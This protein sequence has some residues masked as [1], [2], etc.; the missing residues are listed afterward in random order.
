MIWYLYA[1]VDPL[2]PS[3]ARYVG[4]TRNVK[5]RRHVHTVRRFGVNP[6]LRAWKDKLLTAG[7]APEMRILDQF[8]SQ[9][10]A[11]EREWR[12]ILRW[13]RRGAC[14]LNQERFGS[15]RYALHCEALHR[16]R[17]TGL[18]GEGAT[19]VQNS[20]RNAE[21]AHHGGVASRSFPSLTKVGHQGVEP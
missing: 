8:P 21:T 18:P 13:K 1:L 11:H 20:L 3:T 14:D 10:E 4:I 2:A 16:R 19:K 12:T 17:R 15:K 7:R 5:S 9:E 6:V